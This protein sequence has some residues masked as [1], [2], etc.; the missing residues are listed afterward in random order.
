MGRLP[1][2][3]DEL[4]EQRTG[5]DDPPGRA[6]DRPRP[7]RLLRG[8][9]LRD[10]D[11]RPETEEGLNVVR[12]RNTVDAVI[13]CG[14]GG[15]ITSNRRAE[16]GMAASCPRILQASPGYVSTPL[17]RDVRAERART[18]LAARLSPGATVSGA[19]AR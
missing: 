3:V 5:L 11:L 14:K 2:G 12:S 4:V 7:A 9:R 17:L 6:G 16:A 15:K 18:D 8:R 1:V 10:P 13:G 19:Q